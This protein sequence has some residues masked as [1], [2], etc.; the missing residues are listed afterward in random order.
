MIKYLWAVEWTQHLIK[1]LILQKCR[2]LFLL[3]FLLIIPKQTY[4]ITDTVSHILLKFQ[5]YVRWKYILFNSH[6]LNIF[7]TQHSDIIG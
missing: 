2:L 3:L 7:F 5:M 1:K 4:V 6:F